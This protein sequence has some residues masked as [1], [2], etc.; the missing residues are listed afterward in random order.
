MMDETTGYTCVVLHVDLDCFYAAVNHYFLL[1]FCEL[2]LY[3][4]RNL[5]SFVIVGERASGSSRTP[6]I[7]FPQELLERKYVVIAGFITCPE[8]S[9][10]K[11]FTVCKR[12]SRVSL[13]SISLQM[14]IATALDCWCISW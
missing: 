4:A 1:C 10:L 13:S 6:G 5:C 11:L 2:W 9:N 3:G 7:S 14:Q 12:V 8:K